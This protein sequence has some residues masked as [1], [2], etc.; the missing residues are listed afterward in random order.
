MTFDVLKTGLCRS[1]EGCVQY[2]ETSEVP[3]SLSSRSLF[4]ET[5][6]SMSEKIREIQAGAD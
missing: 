5:F 6:K 1:R 2:L 3:F 4:G